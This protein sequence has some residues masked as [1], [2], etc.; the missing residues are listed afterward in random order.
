MNNSV[1]QCSLTVLN[2]FLD[3]ESPNTGSVASPPS[4]D[5]P[6]VNEDLLFIF[7]VQLIFYSPKGEGLLLA[8]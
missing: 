5:H 1:S 7:S 3:K 4:S 8:H 6:T 2:L